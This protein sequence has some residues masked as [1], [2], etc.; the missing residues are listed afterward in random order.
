MYSNNNFELVAVRSNIPVVVNRLFVNKEVI[1]RNG[2][3]EVNRSRTKLRK[4]KTQYWKEIII[5]S[6]SDEQ[7]IISIVSSPV[8]SQ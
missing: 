4:D 5:D 7:E 1:S 3:P 6:I 2:F 8:S